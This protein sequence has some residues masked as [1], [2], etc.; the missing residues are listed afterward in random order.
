MSQFYA[1]M[2]DNTVKYISLKEDIVTDIR[3]LFINGGAKLKP[4]GIEEDIFDGNIV[5]RN[6]ENITYVN[7]NLPEDFLRVPDNQADMSEYNINEDVP[8]SIFYYVDGKFYFQIFNK[9]NMLQR[10]MVLQLFEY[11]NVFTKMNNT[12]FIVEDKVHAIYENGKL[13]FQ[14]YTIANQIFSLIDFVTE[15][16]NTEIESFGEIK[17]IDVSAENIKHI[18]NIKTR[19]LIKLLSSTNNITTFMRKASRTKTSL[20][21]KYGINAQINGDNELVLP[22]DNV[23]E[24]NRTLEFLNEDIFRGVIT[25]S[26]YRSNSKKKTFA[27]HE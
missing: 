16:T 5:S 3:N 12:A 21:K 15:A 14:S 9:K 26:L 19:R 24:L 2:H 23:V 1:L 10:K 20:L 18:A 11:G 27:N 25:D 7:Y 4:E 17:G 8:K 22:T 6:G 13:Y